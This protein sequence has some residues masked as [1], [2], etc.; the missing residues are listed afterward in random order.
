LTGLDRI[1]LHLEVVGS[2]LLLVALGHALAG[3]LAL[4]PDGHEA[5]TEP[6]RQSRAKEEAAALKTHDNVDAALLADGGVEGG[7]DLQGKSGNWRRAERRFTLRL[8]SS[9]GPEA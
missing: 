4:L 1:L 2:V 6:E 7:R 8:E 9:A 3:Q 5:R